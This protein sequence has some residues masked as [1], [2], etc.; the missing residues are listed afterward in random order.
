[1][2]VKD[3]QNA[4]FRIWPILI[5]KSQEARNVNIFL[6]LAD[7]NFLCSWVGFCQTRHGSTMQY[8]QYHRLSW[9]LEPRQK[10]PVLCDWPMLNVIEATTNQLC[11]FV[12]G[13]RFH[14][15]SYWPITR[16]WVFRRDQ[17]MRWWLCTSELNGLL[18]LGKCLFKVI[19][20]VKF[21][22]V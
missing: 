9:S 17:A 20:W 19:S 8:N 3:V 1:M 21:H 16:H 6:F 12:T 7:L 4:A 22:A 13:C 14:K 11:F 10:T 18:T 2:T 15:I 5:L